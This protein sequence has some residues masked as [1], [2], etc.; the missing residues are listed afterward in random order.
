MISFANTIDIDREPADVYAYIAE[1]EHT[2]E[3]N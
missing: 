2:P 1:L 3:W